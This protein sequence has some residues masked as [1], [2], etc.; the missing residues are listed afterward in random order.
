MPV[1]GEDTDTV[2]VYG[3]GTFTLAEGSQD[4]VYKI[5]IVKLDY[6]SGP[7]PAGAAQE[8]VTPR[9]AAAPVAAPRATTW[10]TPSRR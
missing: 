1:E 2:P 10:V 4:V 6:P 8:A 9:A 7:A 5:T 3:V